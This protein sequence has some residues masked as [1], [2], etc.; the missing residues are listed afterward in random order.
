M[1]CY[2]VGLSERDINKESHVTHVNDQ[3]VACILVEAFFDFPRSEILKPNLLGYD[4]HDSGLLAIT[5]DKKT[6]NAVLL[7]RLF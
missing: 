4:H 7:S 2:I 5:K 6:Y 1:T 3:Y